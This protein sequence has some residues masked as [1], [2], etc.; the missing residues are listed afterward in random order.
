MAKTGYIATIQILIPPGEC[1]NGAEAA[2]WVHGM[3]DNTKAMDW[4]YLKVGGQFMHPA[5]KV[6]SSDYE[7]GEAF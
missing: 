1:N 5:E 4:A 3:M 6:I 2:D 7:E